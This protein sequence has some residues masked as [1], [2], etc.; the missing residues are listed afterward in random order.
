MSFVNVSYCSDRILAGVHLA[1][2]VTDVMKHFPNGN[3]VTQIAV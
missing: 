2:S 1:L 3:P